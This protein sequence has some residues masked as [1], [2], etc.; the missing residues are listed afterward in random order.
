FFADVLTGQNVKASVSIV[1]EGQPVESLLGPDRGRK[2]LIVLREKYDAS[3][4]VLTYTVRDK[5]REIA[6]MQQV[7]LPSGPLIGLP[8]PKGEG[9]PPFAELHRIFKR[10][11]V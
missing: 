4:H 9:S 10:I 7:H 1:G 11:S 2:M 5:E 6:E 8:L 3:D